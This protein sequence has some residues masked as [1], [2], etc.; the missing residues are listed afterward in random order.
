MFTENSCIVKYRS[1][2][3]CKHVNLGDIL[4]LSLVSLFKVIFLYKVTFI[5]KIP[6]DTDIKYWI[7]KKNNFGLI[8]IF[9]CVNVNISNY[10]LIWASLNVLPKTQKDR[11]TD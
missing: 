2:G 8:N 7:F 10:I 3:L 1:I 6:Q 11:V 9:S 4:T 5:K